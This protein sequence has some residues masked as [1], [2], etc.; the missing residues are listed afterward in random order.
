MI[1]APYVSSLPTT[2]LP[3]TLGATDTPEGLT[4]VLGRTLGDLDGTR[5][6]AAPDGG[7]FEGAIGALDEETYEGTQ[8]GVDVGCIDGL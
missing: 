6:A 1:G 2:F 3:F 5:L 7:P 4:P 8:D